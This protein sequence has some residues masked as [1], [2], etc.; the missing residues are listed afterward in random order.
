MK[1]EDKTEVRNIGIRKSTNA[2]KALRKGVGKAVAIGTK[3]K[4]NEK[5]DKRR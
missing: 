1:K 5:E 3:G 2:T 4:K